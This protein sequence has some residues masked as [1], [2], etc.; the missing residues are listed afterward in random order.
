VRVLVRIEAEL[1][2]ADAEVHA[3]KAVGTFVGDTTKLPPR[4]LPS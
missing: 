4:D 3:P 2:L 1:V